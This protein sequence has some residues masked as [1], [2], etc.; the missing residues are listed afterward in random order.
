MEVK[1]KE[2]G[3]EMDYEPLPNRW[4]QDLDSHDQFQVIAVDESER[5]VEIQHLDGDLEEIDMD[6][7]FERKLELI[8]PPEDWTASMDHIERDDLGYSETGMTNEDWVGPK[9][10]QREVVEEEEREEEEQE[11]R[12]P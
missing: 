12:E 7:W 4:Y 6:E 2:R 9:R 3:K 1:Q 5:V 10:E 11:E 8:E